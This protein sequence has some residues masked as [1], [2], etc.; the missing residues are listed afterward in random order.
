MD[1]CTVPQDHHLAVQLKTNLVEEI[2]DEV[3]GDVRVWMKPKEHLR[4]QSVVFAEPQRNRTD[5]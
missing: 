4:L 2:T 1:R 3:A 5:G